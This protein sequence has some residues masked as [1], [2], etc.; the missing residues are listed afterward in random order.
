[1]LPAESPGCNFLSLRL[2]SGRKDE[3]GKT[4]AQQ[5]QQQQQQP[6]AQSGS[7]VC[8]CPCVQV[9]VRLLTSANRK[10]A[11]AKWKMSDRRLQSGSVTDGERCGN[12]SWNFRVVMAETNSLLFAEGACVQGKASA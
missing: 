6:L 12:Q 8:V 1:M 10:S 5:Q 9:C 11:N 4:G 3:T 7:L 2:D